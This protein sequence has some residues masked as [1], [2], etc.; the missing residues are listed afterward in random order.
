[1]ETL[2][3]RLKDHEGFRPEPYRDD[4]GNWTIGHGH[5]L[6]NG[7]SCKISRRVADMILEEDIHKATFEHISLGWKLDSVRRD[8]IIEMIFWHGLQ[9]F[10]LFKKCVAAIEKQDWQK[11][12]DEMMDS[13]SGREYVT[14][15]QTLA[16]LMI[17]GG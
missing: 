14:R 7:Q 16:D 15:M 3:E 1:M 11:A 17:E 2:K 12:A 4:R 5:Y 10:L 9:G 13:N 8:V 6:G